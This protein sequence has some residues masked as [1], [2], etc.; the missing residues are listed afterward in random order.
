MLDCAIDEGAA[1]VREAKPKLL[2]GAAVEFRVAV[3][4]VYPAEMRTKFEVG[5]LDVEPA[6]G[7][8]G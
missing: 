1:F 6:C 4:G 3:A 8:T 5:A 2:E 7:L